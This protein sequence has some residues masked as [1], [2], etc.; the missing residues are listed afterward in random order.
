MLSANMP[1]FSTIKILCYTVG[2][3]SITGVIIMVGHWLKSEKIELRNLGIPGYINFV[4]DISMS[5]QL[6]LIADHFDV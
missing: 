6:L 3:G 5:L 1:K 4:T 2:L